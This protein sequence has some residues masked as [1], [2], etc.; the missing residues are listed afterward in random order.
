MKTCTPLLYSAQ[1]S[2][3][4]QIAQ[5]LLAAK[6]DINEKDDAGK[7]LI[8]K[9]AECNNRELFKATISKWGVSPSLCTPD[10]GVDAMCCSIASGH[11]EFAQWLVEKE[12]V[13]DL[14]F[15][16]ATTKLS[17]FLI[18]AFKG[19]KAICEW[20]V[21]TMPEHF[22]VDD[23]EPV[24]GC[25][26]LHLCAVG[27][28]PAVCSWLLSHGADPMRKDF[29]KRTPLEV[30]QHC[31]SA[32]TVRV[33]SDHLAGMARSLLESAVS[34]VRKRTQPLE[35][36]PAAETLAS[37]IA[38][39]QK[40][41]LP[42]TDAAMTTAREEESSLRASC[43]K[44]VSLNKAYQRA[45]RLLETLIYDN[46]FGGKNRKPV[47]VADPVLF[48][49]YSITLAVTERLALPDPSAA[50]RKRF[51]EFR[52][53]ANTALDALKQQYILHREAALGARGV[54][55]ALR[56]FYAIIG[57]SKPADAIS[58]SSAKFGVNEASRDRL[59][60][61]MMT[62]YKSEA[63]VTTDQRESLALDLKSCT[64]RI[65]E[66]LSMEAGMLDLVVQMF[67]EHVQLKDWY[68]IEVTDVESH[69]VMGWIDL[70][71]DVLLS[72]K[73][74]PFF[75]DSR[76]NR[77]LN[78]AER[79][80][81]VQQL[82]ADISRRLGHVAASN[83][84]SEMLLG[85]EPSAQESAGTA[86]AAEKAEAELIAAEKA[87]AERIDA[88]K[89]EAERLAAE[90]AEA[91]RIAAEKA[92]AE[93]LA[94]EKAEVERI[95]VEKAEAAEKAEAE[96]IAAQKAEAERIAAIAAKNA[97]AERLAAEKAEA[98]RLAAAKAEAERIAAEK[99]EAERL[100][101][102]K[103][104][105]ERLA[106]EKAEA[107][108]IAAK[109][110]E[111]ER[112][113]AEQAEA[114]RIEAEKAEAERIAAEKAEAERIE[115]E[116]AEAERVAAEKAEAE[117]V[118]AEKAEAERLAAE[119]AEAERIAAE[120]AE[121]ERIAAEKA[122]AERIAAEKAEAERVA[123][124]KAEAERLAAE[125]AE[126]ERIAAEKAE[127][128]RIAAEKAEA[129]RIATEKAEA[130]RIAA[131]KAEAERIAAEKAE[132]ERIAAEKAE[133][134]RIAA[135]KAEAERIAAEKAEA[136]RIAAEKAEAE[137]IA[138]EKAEAERIAAEKAEAERI[139]AE[140]AEAER[141]AAEK[142]EAERIAEKAEAERIA[143]EKAEAERI[144]AEKAEAERIAAE[145]AEAERIAAEKAEA[146]R[147]AAEKAEAERIAAEK[148]EA[149]RIAA[150]KAEAERIA[151]E[152]A[153]AERIAAEKA[154]AERIAAEKAEAERIAAE[155][156][157]ADRIAAEQAEAERIA[158]Q[159]DKLHKRLSALI[160]SP[161]DTS[162]GVQNI[163]GNIGHIE[164][165]VHEA[166]KLGVN[167]SAGVFDQAKR[168]VS[169][170]VWC[171]TAQSVLQNIFD[172]IVAALA[173]RSP[174]NGSGG[175]PLSTT[176]V[177]SDSHSDL[178]RSVFV[179]D[180]P[181]S[182]LHGAGC[183]SAAIPYNL[184][185]YAQFLMELRGAANFAR[186]CL[187]TTL[188]RRLDWWNFGLLVFSS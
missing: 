12:F 97:E 133:A 30:A 39:A 80:R 169:E 168:R 94:A 14:K 120:K 127:A 143:A 24:Q 45:A 47:K 160:S 19:H 93:R 50:V 135:E 17:Y 103:A 105:A 113:A 59:I 166:K 142:A 157:E 32:D 125:K 188:V 4:T 48:I 58:R 92:E 149:E 11:L 156:A 84:L 152:K 29:N 5:Q 22:G 182:I 38:A 164:S 7:S 42:A 35:M 77:M 82:V 23:S 57:V 148:A 163:K 172:E 54:S 155:K 173:P 140:K 56:R 78:E 128:E 13:E 186:E 129:E 67:A 162:G 178:F 147:I 89:A 177:L 161:I 60:G 183:P 130:E 37:A 43:S 18:A 110:A 26:A 109:K 27:N 170:L 1:N 74:D 132:A 179:D 141:I 134:E 139:A 126:A 90:K 95:A 68:S 131:E 136:E 66:R 71:T 96:R 167:T 138:A 86:T 72:R 25:T 116:K 115:A 33:I 55:A 104:E 44:R 61:A 122:E 108:R 119:K 49:A 117:R 85:S 83:T 62:K 118:A 16:T 107:E 69:V 81:C 101:A 31:K 180:V 151:A 124:A 28:H 73:D 51:A 91:Q 98:E 187:R 106:A 79:R 34:R 65:K 154:E 15:T 75:F 100:A 3:A 36:E 46:A 153:E 158:A 165:A 150:E 112:R 123:A 159:V 9:A 70:S 184:I 64:L 88:E 171:L 52:K 174:T 40:M 114:E 53:S 10:K 121:A 99:A 146:E 41:G 176:K 111:A 2:R 181:R 175:R 20:L 102:E 6:A 145:K 87:E 8:H 144:A 137:R 21:Q 185:K 76:N 63:S